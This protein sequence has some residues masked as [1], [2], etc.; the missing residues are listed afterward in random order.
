MADVEQ[1]LRAKLKLPAGLIAR[2]EVRK[3][4]P[5]SA[6]NNVVPAAPGRAVRGPRD[7]SRQDQKRL[8]SGRPNSRTIPSEP[9]CGSPRLPVSES[10][11]SGGS[12]RLSVGGSWTSSPAA[13]RLFSDM[14]FTGCGK[15]MIGIVSG[16]RLSVVPK[17]A[18]AL[19]LLCCRR[20][21]RRPQVEAIERRI[22]S[23]LVVR[24]A[25]H[26]PSAERK[27]RYVNLYGTTKS[28]CPDTTQDSTP[29]SRDLFSP[30]HSRG[31]ALKRR[32]NHTDDLEGFKAF[33]RLKVGHFHLESSLHSEHYNDTLDITST[34]RPAGGG[35]I[36][37]RP[38]NSSG[39]I[40]KA[41]STP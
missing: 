33:A 5:A 7:T 28:R 2:S 22:A 39:V 41:R 17:M 35:R 27:E 3:M 4:A 16:H 19:P 32:Q 12:P 21:E 10:W 15:I 24:F 40:P 36:H 26:M 11:F 20:P 6:M 23:F 38:D 14:G 9:S 34:K 1:K 25:A 18:A 31:P 13:K 8:T 29:F 37:V 30:G